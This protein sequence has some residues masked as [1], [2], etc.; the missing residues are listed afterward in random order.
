MP[1]ARQDRRL[2]FSP[3]AGQPITRHYRKEDIWFPL[4]QF[5]NSAA[6]RTLS[7]YLLVGRADGTVNYVEKFA[8]QLSTNMHLRAFPFDSQELE[9]YIHPF[10]GRVSRIVLIVF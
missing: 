10:T 3:S 2:A 5:D 4:L 9:L 8:V 1:R 6:P 7:S